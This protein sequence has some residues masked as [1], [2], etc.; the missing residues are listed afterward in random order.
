[1]PQGQQQHTA[2]HSAVVLPTTSPT[3][4]DEDW[5]FRSG[6]RR[7]VDDPAGIRTILFDMGKF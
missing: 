4:L 2:T 7:R 3:R 6:C 5:L 1:M